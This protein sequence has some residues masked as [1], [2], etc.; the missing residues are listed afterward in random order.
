MKVDR[1]FSIV[2]I[3]INKKVVTAPKLAEKFNVSTRTI[4]RDIEVL[5]ESGIPI[6]CTRGKGGG[7]SIID[8]YTID[9]A[10]FSDNEQ[11]Q[12]LMALGS[13]SATGQ[14]DVKESLMKISN[15]FKKNEDNWIEID[16]SPWQQND[17][18]KIIFE[19]LKNAIFNKNEVT[20]SYFN[21]KGQHSSR[22]VQPYKLVFK[23]NYWYLYGFCNKKQDMRFFK[24][25]RI[26]ELK[27]L[28]SIFL[29]KDVVND[30]KYNYYDEVNLIDIK[31]KV[32]KLMGFRVYDEFRTGN[33]SIKNDC[34]IVSVKLPHDEWLY[35]YLM[36]FGST[37]EI[38]EPKSLRMEYIQRVQKIIN[39]YL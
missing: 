32:D 9:K 21:T 13:V 38:L 10:M 26:D 22:I 8:G 6:Y 36:S 35:N 31:L 39:K 28:D 11:K 23:L 7:I 34:F 29:K 33:I 20:F 16:F 25:T 15:I 24:L 4:Y 19:K 1:L 27:V 12:I 37:I 5:C 30:Y 14:L 2:D 3:L 18:D 17:K